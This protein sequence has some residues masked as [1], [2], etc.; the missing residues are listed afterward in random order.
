[1]RMTVV[2]GPLRGRK[3]VAGASTHGCWLGT[4]EHDKLLLFESALV[5]GD[6]VYDIGAHVGLYS[7]VASPRI[8]S[9]GRVYAFEP[10]PRNVG[11]LREHMALNDVNNCIV[12]NAAVGSAAGMAEFDTGVHPAMGHLGRGGD[13]A[14]TVRTVALDDLVLQDEIRPPAVMKMDIEGA[15]HE[16]LLGATHILTEHR[17]VIFLATHSSSVHVSCCELLAAADF[18]VFPIDGR[19]L[20]DSTELLALPR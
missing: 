20:S 17:P 3:W 14:I 10:A 2:S 1:M 6:V 13:R 4:Y 16:A 7:L 12:L 5:E 11:Y 19:P 18:D 9:H 15:E 8:G